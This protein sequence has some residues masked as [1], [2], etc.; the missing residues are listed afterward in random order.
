MPRLR[1]LVLAA[2]LAAANC[3]PAAVR[4]QQQPSPESMEAAQALFALVFAHGFAALNAQAVEAAWPGIEN[5]VR[6]QRPDIA[7]ATL[8]DL[9]REFERIRLARMSEA[10]KDV[11]AIYARHLSADD[12]RVLAAFYGTSTGT[13]MLQAMPKVLPEAFASVLPRMQSMLADTQDSF[14]KLLRAWP[15]QLTAETTIP[16]ERRRDNDMTRAASPCRPLALANRFDTSSSDQARR[17]T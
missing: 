2:A 14:L 16:N 1:I 3:L 4:A 12:M 13:R 6:T 5:A 10:V 9:R 11:P 17:A 7:A 8:A 15:A